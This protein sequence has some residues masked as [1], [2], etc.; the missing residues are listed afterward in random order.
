MLSFNSPIGGDGQ[1]NGNRALPVPLL[2]PGYAAWFSSRFSVVPASGAASAVTS[3][4][5]KY[6]ATQATSGK[7]PTIANNINGHP[8]LDF[9]TASSQELTNATDNILNGGATRYV[10]IVAKATTV[11]GSLFYFQKGSW[12]LYAWNLSGTQYYFSDGVN[13]YGE[14]AA[15]APSLSAAPFVIEWELAQGATPVVRINN[16]ART[17]SGTIGVAAA[18]ITGF[19]IGSAGAGGQYWGGPIADIYIAA[20]VPS[21]ANKARLR[22]Y[23][24]LANGIAL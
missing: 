6:T 14:P 22:Q 9:V 5:P 24:A 16:V 4:P 20:G 10:L 12:L 13:P 17:L 2:V 21:T 11:G 23:F 8:S 1:P 18:G 19:A 3:V 7:R 15:S